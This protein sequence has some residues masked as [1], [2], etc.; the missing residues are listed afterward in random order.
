M[1]KAELG[2]RDEA[3]PSPNKKH[4]ESKTLH[5]PGSNRSAPLSDP[6]IKANFDSSHL[7]IGA[8]VAIF[9]LA[10]SCV[11]VCRHS[12]H[13]YWFLP[14]G[15]RDA[16]EDTP[17]GAE[18]EGFEEVSLPPFAH[19]KHLNNSAMLKLR[20]WQSGYR[21]RLLPIPLPH[22][23]PFPHNAAAHSPFVREPVWTQLVPR[24]HSVQ[25]LLFWYIAETVPP[26]VE[27][28]IRGP[29]ATQPP[30][31]AYQAPPPY[32]DGLTLAQRIALEPQGYR[33]VHHENTATEADEALYESHLLPVETAMKTLE[34]TVSADVVRRGWAAICLRREMEDRAE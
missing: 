31:A 1:K 22:S 34:G 5:G 3:S 28:S 20:A 13:K 17:R 16:G 6:P 32:P 24:S 26:D 18:R 2:G 10:S 33:P 27:A 14:K 7:T 11:I 8:G 19:P 23:Q 15:R 9:H 12:V 30:S 25:Y 29:T 21:N 4:H